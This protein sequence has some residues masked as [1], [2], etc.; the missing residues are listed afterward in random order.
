MAGEE[1]QILKIEEGHFHDVKSARTKPAAVQEDFVAFANSDSG[2]LYIGVEDRKVTGERIVGFKVIE[3]ANDIIGVL[4][5]ETKPSVENVDIEFIDFDIKGF[6]LHLIIPKSSQVH[7][8]SKDEC[9]IRLNARSQKIKGEKITQ[10]AYA[11]GIYSYEKV[12]MKQLEVGDVTS[13]YYLTNYMLR[14]GSSQEPLTF[15]RKQ[16]LLAKEGG[17]LYPNIGALLMFDEEPQACLDKRCAI[18]VYRI[19]TTQKDYKR[20]HLEGMPKTI[21]GPIEEQIL[22]TIETVDEFLKNA[23]YQEGEKLVKLQYPSEALKEILV[24]AVI[25]R[26]YSLNDDIHVRIYDNRIEVQS[27]GK[28]PGY[29]TLN[30]ILQERYSRNPNMVRLLHKLPNPLNHDIGEG[31]NTVFNEMRKAGLVDP[32]IV[33]LENAVLVTIKHQRLASLED[34]IMEYLEDNMYITNRIARKLSGEGSENK[35]KHAFQR[36]R[37]EGLIEPIDP[38]ARPFQFKYRKKQ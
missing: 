23:T 27:P 30:N 24:N 8:T 28:L 26:D 6:V 22:Q 38:N 4:L 36:L 10:L 35:V 33:E 19:R 31:L 21:N 11:K 32:E 1:L 3:E 2:E 12:P 5:T 13:S 18:K 29:I 15:L 14:V 34:I 17:V 37:S 25:H 16:G 20:E 7:Y 9:F